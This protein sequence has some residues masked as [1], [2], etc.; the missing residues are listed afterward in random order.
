MPDL[1]VYAHGAL[2]YLDDLEHRGLTHSLVFAGLC[3]AIAALFARTLKTTPRAAFIFIGAATASHGLLDALTN[4]GPGIL[5]FWPFSGER[6]F[7]PL[8]VIEVS[9]LGIRNFFTTRALDVLASELKWLWLPAILLG[10]ILRSA[11]H[12]RHR[13]N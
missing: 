1:D 8:P 6:Y 5:F 12:F 3:G 4:G 10:L 7:I 2:G 13:R 9:P 11:V